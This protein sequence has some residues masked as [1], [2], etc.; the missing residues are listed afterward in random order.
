M[1]PPPPSP[2]T[3][4]PHMTLFRRPPT[5]PQHLQQARCAPRCSP[6][7]APAAQPKWRLRASSW[8]R[9]RRRRAQ[10]RGAPGEVGHRARAH[11]CTHTR[12]RTRAYAH[13]HAHAHMCTHTRM[14]THTHAHAHMPPPP[15][16]THTHAHTHTGAGHGPPLPLLT[17]AWGNSTH[18]TNSASSLQLPEAVHTRTHTHALTRPLSTR[19]HTG[20]GHGPPLPLLTAAWGNSTSA[21]SLQLPEA[22][23]DEPASLPPGWQLLPTTQLQMMAAYNVPFMATHACLNPQVGSVMPCRAMGMMRMRMGFDDIDDDD[24]G[25]QRAVHGNARVPQPPGAFS[26]VVILGG[27]GRPLMMAS[28]GKPMLLLLIPGDCVRGACIDARCR[29]CIP[30]GPAQQRLPEP[31]LHAR[32]QGARRTAAVHGC[33]RTHTPHTRTTHTHV[34]H[35]SHT[36]ARGT[37][38]KVLPFPLPSHHSVT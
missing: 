12:A 19:A 4:T 21:S 10:A 13:A 7:T 32:P 23:P 31:A 34:P 33:A 18:S 30:A 6:P 17:G 16:H 28:V 20:A 27:D 36:R 3:H 14:R 9:E 26:W 2:H 38:D 8:D 25:V 1:T 11:T 29:H 5:E 35:A 24:G 22:V 37:R 15:T